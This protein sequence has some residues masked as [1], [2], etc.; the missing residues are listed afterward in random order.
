MKKTISILLVLAMLFAFAAC[1]KG[2]GEN[3]PEPQP[4]DETAFTVNGLEFHLDTEKEFKGLHYVISGD[5]RE[6]EHDEFTPYVQYNFLQ[7]DDSNLL[8]YRIFYYKGKGTDHAK[9]DLGLEKDI[10]LTDGENEDLEYKMYAQP[11]DDGGTIHYYFLSK[12]GN[13]Y[14]VNFVSKYDIADFEQKVVKSLKF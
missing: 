1:G 6:V 13:T 7:E 5:F 12:D 4:A 8:F 3:D 2:K 9:T 11:R 10:K 14:V